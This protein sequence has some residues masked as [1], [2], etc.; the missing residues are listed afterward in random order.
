ML[1]AVLLPGLTSQSFAATENAQLDHPL[2]TSKAAAVTI[3]EFRADL[4]RLPEELRAQV[5]VNQGR[6][7]SVIHNLLKTKTLAAEARKLGLDKDPLNARVIAL[8]ADR[9]LTAL[10]YDHLR[11]N[12]GKEFDSN[13][14]AHTRRARE[15][16]TVQA[17][18]HQVPDQVRAAHIL[19]D[20]KARS[21]DEAR[22]LAQKLRDEINGGADFAALAQKYSDDPGSKIQGGDL[23]FFEA[24]NM[25]KSFAD[26]AFR[27]SATDSLGAVVQSK[28]GFH[29]IKF[30]DRKPGR[31]KGF[32]EV[33]G[34]I[35]AELRHQFITDAFNAMQ[36]QFVT[37]ESLVVDEKALDA[38]YLKITPEMLRAAA[39]SVGKNP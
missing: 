5:L 30:I 36:R 4:Q 1:F 38:L 13:L 15:I 9:V 27:L 11:S 39:E 12:A 37:D 10:Y 22:A 25:V 16:Y 3:G 18:R 2:A 32:D 34:A 7:A 35:L 17:E 21:E 6:V 26:E 14:D 20:T 19:I 31:R 24:K 8:G 33:K 23:G 28:F 29:V